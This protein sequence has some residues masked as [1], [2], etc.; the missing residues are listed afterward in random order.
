MKIKILEDGL[1]LT[2]DKVYD[3]IKVSS[4]VI[5]LRNDSGNTGQYYY[6]NRM[7]FE[8][9]TII[10]NRDSIIEDILK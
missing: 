1:L 8:D 4:N 10:Y 2:K 6:P 5:K 3:A 9:V 7:Y